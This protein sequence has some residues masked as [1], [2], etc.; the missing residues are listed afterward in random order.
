MVGENH[1]PPF[2]AAKQVLGDVSDQF[3]VDLDRNTVVWELLYQNII[4]HGVQERISRTDKTKRQN[5]IL[6]MI[7]FRERAPKR[8]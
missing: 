8:P 6:Y 1:G 5:E 4:P 3:I 7:G 2:H